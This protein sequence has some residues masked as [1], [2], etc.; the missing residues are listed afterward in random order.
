LYGQNG[1][2]KFDH[3]QNSKISVVKMV[4]PNLI[5]TITKIPD[6]LLLKPYFNR[7]RLCSYK[8]SNSFNHE[9]PFP[10][11]LAES[12]WVPGRAERQQRFIP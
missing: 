12:I 5:M 7:P 10:D 9:S 3:S 2:T 1:Q 4:N 11:H 8:R 6:F